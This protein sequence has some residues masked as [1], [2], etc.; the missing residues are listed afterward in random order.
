MKTE[1][2]AST[3][4]LLCDCV[5]PNKKQTEYVDK[6]DGDYVRM[7][8]SPQSLY[9]AG[10][11]VK[12]RWKLVQSALSRPL[13]CVED[14]EEAILSY[15]SRFKKA[16]SFR[17]LKHF[18]VEEA[19]IDERVQ[20]F[21]STLPKMQKLCLNAESFFPEPPRLLTRESSRSVY[22]SQKQASILMLMAFFCL[23]PRRNSSRSSAE[24]A[25]Y[26]FINF[27]QLFGLAPQ[28]CNFE[29]FRSL[30]NY[31][32]R[33]VG[34]WSPEG[35]IS[36]HRVQAEFET[37]WDREECKMGRVQF[38]DGGLIDVE[39]AKYIEMD[40]ANKY[41]GG[42][43]L[44]HGLVQE[45]IRFIVAPELIVTLL[46]TEELADDEC[47]GEFYHCAALDSLFQ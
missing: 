25:K 19:T 27:N 3:T 7:P 39:G 20:F 8:F 13:L 5:E 6:W 28:P 22:M 9:P 37:M 24:Y 16:W 29:K 33:V 15:N 18:F 42:G 10:D 40:F 17:L 26:N 30:L 45:E 35:V 14:L 12:P 21:D 1:F 23:Y 34:D 41:I 32:T 4:H 2:D 46:L 36:F 38:D 44:G 11:G 31:F 47:L 43:V